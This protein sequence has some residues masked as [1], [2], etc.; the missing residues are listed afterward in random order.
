MWFDTDLRFGS[1]FFCSDGEPEN[2]LASS[3]PRV[4][5]GNLGFDPNYPKP[6][7]VDFFDEMEL[8]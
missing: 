6:L 3:S 5:L 1:V 2:V 8:Q 7:G 4:L